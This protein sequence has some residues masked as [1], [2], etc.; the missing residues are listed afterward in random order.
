MNTL[1]QCHDTDPSELT[2]PNGV[3]SLLPPEASHEQMVGAVNRLYTIQGKV[4]D[5]VQA[6]HKGMVDNGICPHP[7]KKC[8][9]LEM[10]QTAS[11][12]VAELH[13]LRRRDNRWMVFMGIVLG[14][15]TTLAGAWLSRSTSEAAAATAAKVAVDAARDEVRKAQQSTADIAF[16]AGRDGAKLGAREAVEALHPAP[17]VI[18]K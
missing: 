18:R 17:L 8:A 5:T 4:F 11:I 1:H 10:V 13:G 16:T 14:G 7:D 6:I 12:G 3:R 9:A 2:P 15:I